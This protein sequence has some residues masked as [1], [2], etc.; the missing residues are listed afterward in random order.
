MKFDDADLVNG[1][2]N[3]MNERLRPALRDEAFEP[4]PVLVV[5]HEGDSSGP[6]GMK[7][8]ATSRFL[9]R[10]SCACPYQTMP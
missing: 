7:P 1:D 9:P 4:H 5:G 8:M 6:A 3:I 2:V 10:Q